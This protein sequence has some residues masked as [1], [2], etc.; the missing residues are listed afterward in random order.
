MKRKLSVFKQLAISF[1]ILILIGG[2]LLCLPF[3]TR[4]GQSTSFINALFTSVSATCVTGLVAYDTNVQFTLFGQL[5]I[6]TL[7]QLGGLGFMTF[8]SVAFYAIKGKIGIYQSKLVSEIA[9]EENL[10]NLSSLLKRVIL[11]TLCFEFAGAIILAT[12]FIPDFGSRGIYLAIWHSISA[13]CNAG[14]D[15]LTP[16]G[17][18]TL[19]G[20]LAPY[21]DDG[22]VLNTITIL[23]LIG[24]LGF[25]VW[26][27]LLDCKFKFKKLQ[28]YTKIVLIANLVLIVLSTLLFLLFDYDN[29]IFSNLNF[30]EKLS[31]AFFHSA[32]P[33]TAG[34]SVIDYSKMSESGYLL[35]VL[36]MFIGANSCS[37]AG[38]VKIN[39]VVILL[40]TA[41]SVFK[42]KHDTDCAYKRITSHT[43]KKA[44]TIFLCYILIIFI[45]MI[46]IFNF[47][48]SNDITFKACFFEVVSAL[49]TVGLTMSATPH[50][51]IA[52]KIVIMILMYAGR[53]GIFTIIYALKD[54]T[55]KG[56]LRKP[57]INLIVG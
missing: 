35:T 26:N 37:T 45:S 41:F 53:V 24:G 17:S 34:F 43:I 46:L 51:C 55:K 4:D 48:K 3:A 19:F 14:F 8:V 32:T 30:F 2:G 40:I 5:V 23:I 47:E 56:E 39:T 18:N 54:N 31:V 25:F 44:A 29:P 49:S 36:L 57:P 13:F 7:I 6:L 1:L 33:R 28:L 38:G 11:T 10:S 42:N 21:V 15:I 9:G 27:D 52:S 22:V 50:L 20:S 12:R 16:I